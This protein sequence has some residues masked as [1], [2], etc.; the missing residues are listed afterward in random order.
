MSCVVDGFLVLIFTMLKSIMPVFLGQLLYQFQIDRNNT[1]MDF[2]E[3]T[4]E[5]PYMRGHND[6]GE[7]IWDQISDYMVFIW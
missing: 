2:N 1:S 3:T 4:T 7:S 6:D 5:Q